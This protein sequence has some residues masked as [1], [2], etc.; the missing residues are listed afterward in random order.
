TMTQTISNLPEG[1]YTV[2]ALLRGGTNVTLTLSAQYG[3]E[4]FTES[5]TGVGNKTVEGSEY[6]NGW[7]RLSL[8]TIKVKE[9][10]AITIS[11]KGVGS[12]S[13]WW[14]ADHF[15]MKFVSEESLD[16]EGIKLEERDAW[17]VEREAKIFDLQGREISTKPQRGIYIKNK[18]KHFITY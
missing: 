12:G 11:A 17:S 3:A 2:S 15:Q 1:E 8:P 13:A 6:Q 10:E 14:S 16:I 7:M 18:K 5:L 9:G 4:T